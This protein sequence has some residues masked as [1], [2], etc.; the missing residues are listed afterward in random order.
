VIS[1]ALLISTPITTLQSEAFYRSRL[2]PERSGADVSDSK[3][4]WS[5]IG[6]AG[7]RK[8]T[9]STRDLIAAV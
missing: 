1:L 9:R 6:H 5:N 7:F 4:Q 2:D 3:I 8:D